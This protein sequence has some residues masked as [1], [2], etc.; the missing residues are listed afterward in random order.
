MNG[1]SNKGRTFLYRLLHNLHPTKARLHRLNPR[2]T[3]SSFCSFCLE[4]EKEEE[5]STHIYS[6]CGQGLEAMKWLKAV[7][8]KFDPNINFEKS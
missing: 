8:E 3:P 7:L 4:E 2:A 1:L 6:K 5:N